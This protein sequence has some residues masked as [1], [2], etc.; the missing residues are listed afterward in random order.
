MTHGAAVLLQFE[1]LRLALGLERREQRLVAERGDRGGHVRL[2]ARRRGIERFRGER[3][4]D[5]GNGAPALITRFCTGANLGG[6]RPPAPER[7]EGAPDRAMGDAV[8]AALRS[9]G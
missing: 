6:P 1:P 7:P 2:G 5:R 9:G 3:H 4:R 8:I